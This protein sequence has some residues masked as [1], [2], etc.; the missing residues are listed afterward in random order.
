MYRKGLCGFFFKARNSFGSIF[1]FSVWNADAIPGTVAAI[2]QPWGEQKKKWT[3]TFD[4]TMEILYQP[5]TAYLQLFY[6]VIKI[7][8]YFVQL[9][10]SGSVICSLM[11]Y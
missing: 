10:Q 2:L 6:Y 9:L 5:W 3:T 8:P 7:N 1:D 11:Y 4:D